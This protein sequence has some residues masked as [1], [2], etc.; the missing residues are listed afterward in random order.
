LRQSSQKNRF[1]DSNQKIW[2][3]KIFIWENFF[4]LA[5]NFWELWFSPAL[6]CPHIVAATFGFQRPFTFGGGFCKFWAAAATPK[7]GR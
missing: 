1:F 4:S 5:N 3:K 6:N 7:R 2:A